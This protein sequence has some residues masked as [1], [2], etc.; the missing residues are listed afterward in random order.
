MMAATKVAERGGCESDG[1]G[2]VGGGAEGNR[3]GEAEG[4]QGWKAKRGWERWI[5]SR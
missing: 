4:G 3:A 2:E 1:G 5:R